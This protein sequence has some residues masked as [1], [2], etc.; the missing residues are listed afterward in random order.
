MEW[1]V[2][3]GVVGLATLAFLIGMDYLPLLKKNNEVTR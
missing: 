2:T 1:S 3:I